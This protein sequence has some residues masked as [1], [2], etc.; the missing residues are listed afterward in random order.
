MYNPQ[1]EIPVRYL[2]TSDEDLSQLD[3]SK[4]QQF[5]EKND[6]SNGGKKRWRKLPQPEPIDVKQELEKLNTSK[7]NEIEN[8]SNY[9]YASRF[10]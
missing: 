2:P 4:L 1:N 5:L 10:V 9:Y 8:P 7:Y 3:S 6:G